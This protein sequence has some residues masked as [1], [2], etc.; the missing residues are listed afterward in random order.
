[1]NDAIGGDD[2]IVYSF[3]TTLPNDK[4]RSAFAS[5]KSKC[6]KSRFLWFKSTSFSFFCYGRFQ[7][8]QGTDAYFGM[9]EIHIGCGLSH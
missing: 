2:A 6:A 4:I 3:D 8:I 5:L 7:I 1:M 9:E